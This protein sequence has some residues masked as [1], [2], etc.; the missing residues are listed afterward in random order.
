MES[1]NGEEAFDL[2]MGAVTS[3]ELIITDIQM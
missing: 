2:V 1:K 3:F